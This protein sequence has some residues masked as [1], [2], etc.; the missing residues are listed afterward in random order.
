MLI[1]KTQVPEVAVASMHETHL[2]EVDLIN[3]LHELIQQKRAG[4]P[5][6]DAL[7]ASIDEFESHVVQHFA[8]EEQLMRD[9]GFPAYPVH[10]GEHERVLTHI[11]QHT[12]AWRE[13]SDLEPLAVYLET[14]HPQW[15]HNHIA[16]MDMMTAFF[17]ARKGMP[18]DLNNST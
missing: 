15:A 8:G 6:D 4:I 9:T 7:T 2:R 14:I 10:K 3:A 5:V 13:A 18:F 11:R 12:L 16:T 1:D 17:I